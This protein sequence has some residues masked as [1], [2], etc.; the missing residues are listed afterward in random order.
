MKIQ[1][2]KAMLMILGVITM[3]S[4][5]K[6][7]IVTPQS[8]A[9]M[10][11]NPKSKDFGSVKVNT[12]FEQFFVVTNSGK[13]DLKI[14]SFNFEGENRSEFT[15]NATP[16][17]LTSGKTKGFTFTFKPTSKGDKKAT[18]VIVSNAGR[19]EISLTGQGGE[20]TVTPPATSSDVIT[21]AS[22]I[23]TSIPSSLGEPYT[24]A[25]KFNRYAKLT[26]PN[27][28]AIHIVVQDKITDEQIKRC[29]NILQHYLTNY[30]GSVYGADKTAVANKMADN[31]AVLCLLNGK[32]GSNPMGEQVA[33]QPLYQSEIQVEGHSWYM[34]QDYTHRDAAYEEILHFVHDNGIGVD[35]NG[36]PSSRGALPEFQKLISVS[37]KTMKFKNWLLLT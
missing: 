14:T 27:G 30:P 1:M 17:T 19:T 34:T 7:E 35:T 6:D 26:A 12:S 3:I 13:V 22:A 11:V 9:K 20:T 5:S 4:C 37:K 23:T 29:Q 31:N 25:N 18:L 15:T 8:Q 21:K 33:G 10:A 24:A 36:T 2:K 28:K 16:I 32:D